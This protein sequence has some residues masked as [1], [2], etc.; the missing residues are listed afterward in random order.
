MNNNL[1][2]YLN[3]TDDTI[4]KIDLYGEEVIS[5]NISIAD[6]ADI[7]KRNSTFSQNFTIPATKNNN[8]LLN[9]IFN[10]G[11]DATFDARKKT[12]CFMLSDGIPVFTGS[13]QLIKIK[14]NKTNVESYDCVVYGEVA[15][16][17]K[18][19]GPS[20]LTDLDFSELNHNRD[21]D[22]VIN[23]WYA[24]TK[25][26]GYYYP[27]IDYGYDLDISELNSGILSI[28]VSTGNV[29]TANATTITDTNQTWA[30]NGFDFPNYT[31]TIVSGTGAG[32]TRTIL[33]N[34]AVTLT[35]IGAPL[36]PIP[37]ITS[38][39]SVNKIDSSNPYNS[40]GQGLAP[41]IFKPALSNTYIFKK[42]LQSVGF[43]DDDVFLNSDII[44][45]T[46]TPFTG[47]DIG[48]KEED[49]KTFR[50]YMP[51]GFNP[52]PSLVGIDFPFSIDTGKGYDLQNLYN[53]T[54]HRYTNN[55]A[56]TIQQFFI[57][58]SYKYNVNA[59]VGNG[60]LNPQF[61]QI[62]V[63]FYRSTLGGSQ[64]WHQEIVAVEKCTGYAFLVSTPPDGTYMPPKFVTVG[65]P[66]LN[67]LHV[68]GSSTDYP[69]QPGESFWSRV[70]ITSNT[71]QIHTI[72]DDNCAFYNRIFTNGVVD[73]FIIMND[74][75]PKNVKQI[76]FIKSIITMFNLMVVP[77]K[78]DPKKLSFISRSEYY[79]SGQIKNWTSKVDNSQKIEETLIS[80]QQNSK[81][82]L[83]YK[84]DKDYYNTN[85]TDKTGLIFG[86]YTKDIENEW[87]EGTKKIEVIFSPTPLDKVFGS[88]DIFLP[89]IAK[90]ESNTGLY[91]RTDFNI[92]FLR[93]NKFPMLSQDTLK[94]L[95]K[96]A[97]NVYPYCGH[98]D[99]PINPTIDYNF[100]TIKFAYY[101]ELTSLTANNLISKYWKEYL[102][103]ISD[104][105][106]KLI[107]LKIHLSPADI[108]EFNYND[109]IF[110][111]GLT[112]DGGHYF[113]VNKIN[114][115]MTDNIPS[116][117][118]LIK[119][120]RAPS[121]D[122]SSKLFGVSN[123]GPIS[124][125]LG[126]ISGLVLGDN[127]VVRSGPKII[128]GQG[129]ST[130][131]NTGIGLIVGRDNTVDN[132]TQNVVLINTN[133]RRINESGTTIISNVKFT[134]SGSSFP[135]YDLEDGGEDTVLGP[136][137]NPP[138]NLVDGG[139]D[140]VRGIG[141]VS[142]IM[143]SD[144][145]EDTVYQG[146]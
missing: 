35:L 2:L 64:L 1:E 113:I 12:P 101:P 43:R 9:H 88:K 49:I 71:A 141:G 99:H 137:T 67:P 7:Q 127:P 32:Q 8:I 60:G 79:K 78:Q 75:V 44:G 120:N 97:S 145:G 55:V 3:G 22:H 116:T 16:L 135:S 33:S 111:D 34:T 117:V 109:N 123:G 10:I 56:N 53:T 133:N 107:K 142:P 124:E 47:N 24:D 31:V 102:D 5:L 14:V 87:V 121:L 20:L 130:G 21:A 115:I 18:S 85:Y 143:L 4:G 92:R 54:T 52:Y 27:L 58:F 77:D 81:I 39:Y 25:T 96:P 83:T 106:S 89:K 103:D 119:I 29:V 126:P 100:G 69:A 41:S 73:N 86:E 62:I 70:T 76:D 36:S 80:E 90:L 110:I 131:Y 30:T 61:D 38:V 105:N 72:F 68:M 51:N 132:N 108:A 50:A 112:D 84:S 91:S 139:K 63:G 114:Y 26:L 98:I 95:G 93:K 65:S 11:A 129:N 17:V 28:S 122:D 19:L 48:L 15:D 40:N 144:G 138:Y 82:Q 136:F 134:S 6:V 45:E 140:V 146:F 94:I 74:Y 125:E 23:S 13:F 66:K 104:K 59:Y 128:V 37:D 46:I 57:D 118:E 42:I